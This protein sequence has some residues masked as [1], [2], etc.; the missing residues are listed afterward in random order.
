MSLLTSIGAAA[1]RFTMSVVIRGAPVV[2]L[3]PKSPDGTPG[4][5]RVTIS[6]SFEERVPRA[7]IVVNRSP[8]R[9]THGDP[10]TINMGFDGVTA[11]RFTG[12]IESPARGFSESTIGCVGQLWK[13]YDAVDVPDFDATGM[14]IKEA[15]EN[16]LDL[17]GIVGYTVDSPLDY[18]LGSVVPAILAAGPL[19]EHVAQLA[20]IRDAQV[21]ELSTGQVIVQPM[22]FVPAPTATGI[23][24]DSETQSLAR[25][26]DG[27]DREDW[28]S[29]KN[30]VVVDGAS[31]PDGDPDDPATVTAPLH[32]E[33]GILDSPLSA[34]YPLG[35][36]ANRTA[37]LSQ[38]LIDTEP[39]LEAYASM[40][41]TRFAR[42]A[43]YVTLDLAGDPTLELGQTRA[44]NL[45][46]LDVT[47]RWFVYGLV[48]SDDN[49]P[50]SDG[51]EV[52]GY[53]SNVT[54][55]GGD[56]A[57]GSVGIYPVPAFTWEMEQEMIGVG[58]TP[59]VIVQFDASASFDPDGDLVD[60]NIAWSDSESLLSGTG[61]IKTVVVDPDAITPPWIVTVTVTDSDG[62]VK[63]ASQTVDVSSTA[64]AMQIP[65]IGGAA[66]SQDMY[67]G[68][69]AATWVDHAESDNRAVALRPNDGVHHGHKLTGFEDGHIEL[70][71]DG[72]VT[73]TTVLAAVGSPIN[74][75]AWDWRNTLIA[76]ALTEDAR[77]YVCINMDATTPVFGLYEN[78]RT[79][80]ALAGALGGSG[81]GNGGSSIGLPGDGGIYIYGGTGTGF[82]LIAFDPVVGSHG[83]VQ[84][85]LTGDILTDGAGGATLRIAD[86]TAPGDGHTTIILKNAGGRANGS[87]AIYD[88]VSPPGPS[89]A[90]TRATGLTA[91]LVEG[92]VMVQNGPLAPVVRRALFGDAGETRHV[93]ETTDWLAWT[94]ITNVLPSGYSANHGLWLSDVLTGLPDFD[95]IYLLALTNGG[96]V[97]GLYKS[98]DGLQSVFAIRPMAGV[99]TWP[100]GTLHK[101]S[102][103]APGAAAPPT[104]PQGT[105]A[106]LEDTASP[107][108][109]T[110][111]VASS[112]WTTLVDATGI[113]TNNGQLFASDADNFAALNSRQDQGGANTLDMKVS[114]DGGATWAA[115]LAKANH[116]VKDAGGRWWAY[117][118]ESANSFKIYYSDDQGD[119][120]TLSYTSGANHNSFFL[121]CHPTNQNIISMW[122]TD[123]GGNPMFFN[124]GDRG[125][126]WTTQTPAAPRPKSNQDGVQYQ[127]GFQILQSGRYVVSGYF[128]AG[129]IHNIM[130]SDNGGATWATSSGAATGASADLLI[131]LGSSPGGEVVTLENKTPGTKPLL[132]T[133]S[134]VSFT[135]PAVVTQDLETF[136]GNATITTKFMVY[137]YVTRF[138]YITTNDT[139]F[140]VVKLDLN[141]G[142]WTNLK[143]DIG[144]TAMGNSSMTLVP[145]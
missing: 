34:L 96:G 39:E 73:R 109:F 72:N 82:P 55:R 51:G 108:R 134:A 25:I 128:T 66:E 98:I 50:Q 37:M 43:R 24:Y 16:R 141:T 106:V 132:S 13:L 142:E 65:A 44:I 145:A 63:A 64:S 4:V 32:T 30:K 68:D 103:G 88:S 5:G 92:R 84:Q 105:I 91:G 1:R 137:D 114:H 95:D 125:A 97:G 131:S 143:L 26:L 77:V 61:F 46:I 116:V 10:V 89:A 40:K 87:I 45:P 53:H 110:K 9:Y 129:P 38:P 6:R 56:L 27:S 11:R 138:M 120:W 76:W 101:I 144:G 113:T 15:I 112:H 94:K 23:A 48:E 31:V 41:L 8:V 62:L 42:M 49:S 3:N 100:G 99:S 124:T 35:P 58:T 19:S 130:Y 33:V 80:L 59:R 29:F 81:G 71:R 126:N 79:K 117:T 54:F 93:W 102:I 18:V 133:D 7:E 83:W 139:A 107:K 60:A 127:Y 85:I 67:S 17:A 2:P 123:S 36:G 47:G 90:Y 119:T 78:L 122:G 118:R 12:T 86:V 74:E 136:T 115:G 140:P 69:G 20:D 70:T 14:T 75:I 28:K 121:A 57:G 22:E 21:F 111:L 52:P 135:I 104:T